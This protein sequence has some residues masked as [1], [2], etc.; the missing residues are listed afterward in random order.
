M[1][2]RRQLRDGGLKITALTNFP[3]RIVRDLILDDDAHPQRQF[4]VQAELGGRKIDFVV[5][6]SEFVRMGCRAQ[7]TKLP[8]ALV[9]SGYSETTLKEECPYRAPA[10]THLLPS[11]GLL[12]QVDGRNPGRVVSSRKSLFNLFRRID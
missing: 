6:A 4:A 7:Q 1:V 10:S 5:P 2:R 3:A 9:S 12:I 11:R 8:H